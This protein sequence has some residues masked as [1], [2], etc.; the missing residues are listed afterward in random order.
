MR[1]VLAAAVVVLAWGAARGGAWDTDETIYR[2]GDSNN[3]GVV[4][5]SDV[6]HLSAWLFQ[7]GAEPG[8]LNQ[9]DVND[10]GSINGSDPVY[11]AS[12]LWQGGP[13]PPAPGPYAYSCSGDESALGCASPN[14][15]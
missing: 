5:G 12:W 3:D 4:N 6:S 8:C 10:D 7:G 1:Y 13:M 9:A 15:P 14:C 2:R 11:L